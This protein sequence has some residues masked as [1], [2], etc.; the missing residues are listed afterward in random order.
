MANL[1]TVLPSTLRKF[2]RR[3]VAA[4]IVIILAAPA[5]AADTSPACPIGTLICKKPAVDW[6]LCKKS[7]LLDFH[8]ADLPSSGERSL[9]D[10]EIKG[11]QT[12]SS[13]G[14]N[15]TLEGDAS[16]QQLD[17]LIRADRFTYART[18][19]QWTAEGNVRYQ[20]RDMLMSASDAK[21]TTDPNQATINN[22]R[23]QLLSSRGNGRAA[24]AKIVDS[25]HAALTKATFSTCPLDSPGWEFRAEDIE[26]DQANGIGRAHDMTFRVGDVPIFWLPYASFPID[27]RRKSGFLYPTI[28]Y[29]NERGIDIS[30]PY[31][32][33]LAPNYDVTLTPRL[34]TQRGLMLGGQ[35]RY[36]T[37]SSRGT[38][39][40]EWLANDRD[41]PA[42]SSRSLIH[43]GN[44][45]HFNANWGALVNINHVSDDRYFE[46]FGRSLDIAATTLLPS[47]AYFVGQGSWW[48]A[49]IGGDEYQITDPTLAHSAEPYR[50]L[51]RATFDADQVLVGDLEAGLRSEYVSFSKDSAVD[52]HRLD[53][54]PYLAYPMEAAAWFFR[55][56]LGFR[57]T[58]YQIDR[59]TDKSP[60]R[61]TPIASIDAGL[62]FERALDFAG[63]GYTQT[64]EPRV[65]YLRVPYRDQDN[66]PLFD[67]Q[68]VPFSF[69]QL[70]RSNRF[71]GADRQMDANNLTIALTS[72]LIEDSSGIDRVSAS[73]GQ[74]RYFGDQR[75][76]LPG[77]AETDFNGSTYVGELDLRIND[78]WRAT[79]SN[80][81]NPN[82]DQ[83]D[84]SAVGIQN[85]FG[86]EGVF[87]LSYRFRRNLLEQADASVLIPLNPSWRLVGRWNY[88]MFDRKTLEAFAGI[89]HDSC[90]VAWRLLA[91]R[92]VHN[93][94]R[95]MTNALYFEVEFKGVGSIGQKTGDFLR[96][97]ILGY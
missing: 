57:Y 90:C 79:F 17:Q 75:V 12:Q 60:H 64:L 97:A 25:E 32:L 65:Y 78:R 96:R 9:A 4:A 39:E 27:D 40:A 45:T 66:L 61:G 7:D 89:E 10:T 18:S 76:Q 71:V 46:D 87:N 29:S 51:P 8:V 83:T 73:I 42:D 54:Y 86:R 91:R 21:G 49:R 93:I 41:T 74:I 81:W 84:L 23:Y 88:S 35:F 37:D 67:T 14:E 30:A 1:N 94:D 2:R 53:L 70:F 47:S 85:R 82:T 38:L 5:W 77:R 34:M 69:G 52:A 20:D 26:L 72:R 3:A 43:W 28:G 58:S 50:R 80:Q 44:T 63:E 33:N 55:P 48:K 22:V 56:E 24:T 6:S 92:Y 31:Y 95:D 59:D 16:I 13:D 62:H 36:L 19:T 68:E 11:R 15:Y